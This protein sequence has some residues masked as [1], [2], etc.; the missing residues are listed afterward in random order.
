MR[1]FPRKQVNTTLIAT[2]LAAAFGWQAVQ[3]QTQTQPPLQPHTPPASSLHQVVEQSIMTHPEIRARYHDFRSALEGQSVL[4]GGFRPQVNAQAWVGHEFRSNTPGARDRDWDRPGWTLELRQ[5]IYDGARTRNNVKQA[6]FEKLARYYELM[7]VIDFTAQ[8]AVRAYLD[9]LR[10]REMERL[11]RQNHALHARTHAQ[12]RERF[13]AGVGRRVDLEQAA[14][15]VALA[16]SNWMTEA[17]NLLDVQQRYR[18]LTGQMPVAELEPVPSAQDAL[19]V[20]PENFIPSLR[21]NPEFLAKQALIQAANAGIQSARSNFSPTLEFRATTGQDRGQF[22]NN[23]RTHSSSVQLIASYNLYRGGADSARLRQTTEQRYAARDVRDYTCRNV[24]QELSISWNN[25]ALLQER[26]PF[27]REHLIATQKVRDGYQQQFQI[28]QRSLMDLL[29]TESEL[30]E[31][32]RAL[33]NAE[34]DQLTSQ[35]RWLSLSNRLLST[36]ALAQPHEEMPD[37]VVGLESDEDL[38]VLCDASVSDT[39]TLTP[40]EVQYTPGAPLAEPPVLA[41]TPQPEVIDRI[42]L[43]ADAAFFDFDRFRLKPEGEAL[44][45]RVIAQVNAL[46]ALE[47]VIAIGHTDHTGT[48]EY[49]QRLSER[50]AN[51]VKTYLINH[52]IDAGR[53]RS[54]GRGKTQ[55][56][57]S[58][59]TAEGRAQNRRVEIEIIGTRV[60]GGGSA[61]GAER[62]NASG[63]APGWR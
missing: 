7:A 52:G 28:G 50:R 20:A 57:A 24:L 59:A 43:P 6:G 2:A 14:G 3:A 9:V 23:R 10:Y 38:L 44:L 53:I 16:Q 12:I 37:E 29:D 32:Q 4:R 26:I 46:H 11:A 51:A 58:N 62:N 18:R 41:A 30:F 48:H 31:A 45:D 61:A 8:E 15:R 34:F 47:V 27:L 60:S 19:P 25:I 13:E 35:Y 33:A 40:L 1:H 22:E 55:P 63:V 17:H 42:V 49:N 54:E 36:L 5:M 56:V 21:A 39:Q